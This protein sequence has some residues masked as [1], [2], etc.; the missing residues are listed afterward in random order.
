MGIVKHTRGNSPARCAAI[1]RQVRIAAAQRLLIAA[2]GSAFKNAVVEDIVERLRQR[3]IFIQVIVV[4][5]P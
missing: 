2:Q 5:S 1:P 4:L 3:P